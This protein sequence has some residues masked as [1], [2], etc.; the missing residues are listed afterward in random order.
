MATSVGQAE[1]PRCLCLRLLRGRPDRLL[2]ITD[3]LDTYCTSLSENVEALLFKGTVPSKMP[4]SGIFAGVCGFI[5][6]S[7]KLQGF[8]KVYQLVVKS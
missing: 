7:T 5:F 1:K 3:R 6:K 4:I 8:Q 2:S